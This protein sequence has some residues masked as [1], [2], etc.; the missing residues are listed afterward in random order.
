V[1]DPSKLPPKAPKSLVL[2]IWDTAGQ[3]RFQ[4]LG[5]CYYRQTHIAALVFSISERKSF[6]EIESWVEEVRSRR[7]SECQFVL[8]G[9]KL[10]L[11]TSTGHKREV[12]RAE[13]TILACKLG[14]R[15]I[16][17][18]AKENVNIDLLFEHM[19]TKVVFNWSEDPALENEPP[20]VPEPS[21]WVATCAKWLHS[22]LT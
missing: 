22:W 12:S 10:D 15:Y 8:V 11:V 7:G 5:E 6:D 13:A 16:E 1:I 9:S 21:G 3:E 19:A 20:Q 14:C 2:Q 17:C 4:S 18:S